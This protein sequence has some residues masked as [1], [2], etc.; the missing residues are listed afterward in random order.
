V[1]RRN[2]RDREADGSGEYQFDHRLII[3][4]RL[5]CLRRKSPTE[6]NPP[7]LFSQGLCSKNGWRRGKGAREIECSAPAAFIG[8]GYFMAIVGVYDDRQRI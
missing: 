6:R 3:H 4:G 7:V 2:A 1:S 5:A 8:V